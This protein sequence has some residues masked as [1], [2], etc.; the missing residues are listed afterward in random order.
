MTT[1]KSL[2]KT[3]MIQTIPESPASIVGESMM[4]ELIQVLRHLIYISQSHQSEANNGLN[5][6][7][8]CLPEDLY[9]AFVTNPMA[10]AYPQ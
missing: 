5:L 2:T 3:E 6:L 1:Y 4:K 8:I 10:Q 9:R 7:H